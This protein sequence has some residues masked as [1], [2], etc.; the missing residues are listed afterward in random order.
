MQLIYLYLYANKL[1]Q[2][3]ENNFCMTGEHYRSNKM[4]G[5]TEF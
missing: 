3:L 4:Y 1:Q 2:G 5:L